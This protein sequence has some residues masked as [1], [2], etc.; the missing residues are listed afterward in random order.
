[1]D[2][3]GFLTTFN[4]R[5]TW[6]LAVTTKDAVPAP[7]S[8]ADAEEV[9]LNQSVIFSLVGWPWLLFIMHY[10]TWFPCVLQCNYIFTANCLVPDEVT[11]TAGIMLM[12]C[13]F[14]YLNSQMIGAHHAYDECIRHSS[15]FGVLV[16]YT[17]FAGA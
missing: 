14:V 2:F 11:T 15:V 4:S 17:F 13:L 1:M 16:F 6:P 5:P 12:P 9:S 7:K 3:N 8:S 10:N